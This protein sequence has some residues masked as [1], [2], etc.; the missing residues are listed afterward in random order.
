MSV[1]K[2]KPAKKRTTSKKKSAPISK[3]KSPAKKAIAKKIKTKVLKLK[4]KPSVSRKSLPKLPSKLKGASKKKLKKVEIATTKTT[5]YTSK[6]NGSLIEKKAVPVVITQKP[7]VVSNFPKTKIKTVLVSQPK[8]E[9][10]KS[11]YLDLARKY[12]LKMNFRQFISI[13]GVQAKEFRTQRVSILDHN[14]VILTSRIAIDHYFRM[15]N[16]MRVSI[17]ES[18]KYFCLSESI[19]YYLQKYVQYRKR[20]IFFGHQTIADLV[21]VIKKYKDEK[22]LLPVS[23]V[24]REQIV[25]FLDEIQIKYTKATFYRTVNADLSDMKGVLDYDL[26]VFFTPAGIKSLKENFPQLT[27]EGLRIAA[28]GYNTAQ[29]VQELGFRLDIHSPTPQAPSMT[30]ALDNYLREANKR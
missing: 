14:A 17:P 7:I 25:D 30:M 4:A 26:L 19:A 23:D 21:G 3:K 12:G 6:K 27:Q 2:K 1:K 22:F 13:E 10:D 29:T 9:N 24:H 20:K 16:E 28:F 8:P 18:T 11:P 15:A 5:K